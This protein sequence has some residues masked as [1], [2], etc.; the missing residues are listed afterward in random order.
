LVESLEQRLQD[1]TG[2]VL[3]L[4]ELEVQLEKIEDDL[5]QA[6]STLK[7]SFP[8]ILGS[9]ADKTFAFLEQMDLSFQ[10]ESSDSEVSERSDPGPGSEL[11]R[12][13]Q[14]LLAKLDEVNFLEEQLIELKDTRHNLRTREEAELGENEL[15]FLRTYEDES[16]R[17]KKVLQDANSQLEEL[18]NIMQRSPVSEGGTALS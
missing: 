13:H 10:V 15:A 2:D 18:T 8:V 4:E 16:I 11:S 6:E 14:R 9:E 1:L 7:K 12:A 5:V 3:E 17:L